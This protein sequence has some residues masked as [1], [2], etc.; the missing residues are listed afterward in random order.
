MNTKIL[1]RKSFRVTNDPSISKFEK[2]KVSK[3]FWDKMLETSDY[4]NA[5]KS[6]LEDITV[7]LIELEEYMNNYLSYVRKGGNIPDNKSND[8]PAT[9][10]ANS[11]DRTIEALYQ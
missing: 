8:N 2:D 10:L 3:E 1:L 11:I 7:D 6:I 9:D 5:N 4:I